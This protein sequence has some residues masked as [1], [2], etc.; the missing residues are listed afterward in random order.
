[1]QHF[2]KKI[3][4]LIYYILK[5]SAHSVCCDV[6]KLLHYVRKSFFLVVLL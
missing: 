6:A 1:M 5:Q 2:L 4:R 3:Y